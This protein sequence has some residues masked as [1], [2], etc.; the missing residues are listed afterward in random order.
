MALKTDNTHMSWGR[1]SKEEPTTFP[2]CWGTWWLRKNSVGLSALVWC[3]IGKCLILPACCQSFLLWTDSVIS[4]LIE[5]CRHL[6]TR[7]CSACN[8][9]VYFLWVTH[10]LLVINF[11]IFL[12]ALCG[13][14]ARRGLSASLEER[15]SALPQRLSDVRCG[16]IGIFYLRVHLCLCWTEMM[17]ASSEREPALCGQVSKGRQGQKTERGRLVSSPGANC[18]LNLLDLDSTLSLTC[19]LPHLAQRI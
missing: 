9:S 19:E 16:Y 12:L 6:N 18:A 17:N 4:L 2:S 15:V 10:S 8:Y 7:F 11:H 3:G 5:T 1:A 13:Y 14:K